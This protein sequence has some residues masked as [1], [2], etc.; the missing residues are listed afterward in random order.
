MEN[1]TRLI[2][3]ILSAIRNEL[4]TQFTVIIKLNSDVFIEGGFNQNE[5][6]QVSG[7]LE[8]VGIDA[9]ELSGGSSLNISKYSFSRIGENNIKEEA[10]IVLLQSCIRKKY[11]FL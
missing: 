7:M 4:G 3:E 10:Y 6:L 5:M 9:I 11:R 1:R 8:S 2:L